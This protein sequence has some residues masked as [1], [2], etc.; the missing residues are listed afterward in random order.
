MLFGS[1]PPRTTRTWG[2][3]AVAY[4]ALWGSKSQGAFCFLGVQT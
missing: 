1:L 2:P 3:E 4:L